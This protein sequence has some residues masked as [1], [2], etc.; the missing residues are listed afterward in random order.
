MVSIG[1]GLRRA[2]V[3]AALFCMSSPT[4]ALTPG[5]TVDNFRLVDHEGK[6][7]E[8]YYLSDMRAVV[9]LA[10][11]NGCASARQAANDLESLRATYEPKA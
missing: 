2:P 6:S 10:Q 9:L 5:E 3:L 8:L 11:G 1:W 7:H 4:W